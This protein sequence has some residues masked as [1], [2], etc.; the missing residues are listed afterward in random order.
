M[1]MELVVWVI[2]GM[3]FIIIVSFD[4]YFKIIFVYNYIKLKD[5]ERLHAT[6]IQRVDEEQ[7]KKHEAFR[8]KMDEK[9]KGKPKP[10]RGV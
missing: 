6:T 4:K 2:L 7:K 9:D 3:I 1:D 5:Y 10:G 8:K